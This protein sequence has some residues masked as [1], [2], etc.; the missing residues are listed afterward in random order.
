MIK[1]VAL[2]IP[3]NDPRTAFLRMLPPLSLGILSGDL[4]R[5]NYRTCI[6]DTGQRVDRLPRDALLQFG[7]AVYD[8]R[9][10]LNGLTKC[11][12]GG[13]LRETLGKV[14]PV[15]ELKKYDIVGVSAG[16]NLTL[17]EFH[18]AILMSEF[19]QVEYGVPVVL[20]GPN[21]DSFFG[22]R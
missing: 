18:S 20:G 2:V 17:F 9:V 3:P 5:E 7:R 21:I 16:A 12:Q 19:I 8:S 4:R 13:H 15:D 10:V 14:L 22:F 1:R 6:I 11:T